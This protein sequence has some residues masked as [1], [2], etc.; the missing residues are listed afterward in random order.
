MNAFWIG[1]L[2]GYLLFSTVIPA[3]LLIV[4]NLTALKRRPAITYGIS[5]GFAVVVP[6]LALRGRHEFMVQPIIASCLGALLFFSDY[7]REIKKQLTPT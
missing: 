2:I 5:G 6:L 7:R 3:V 4:L 1:Q